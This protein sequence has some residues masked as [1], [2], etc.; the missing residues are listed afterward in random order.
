MEMVARISLALVV[1]VGSVGCAY[2]D[3]AK[4]PRLKSRQLAGVG[5]GGNVTFINAQPSAEDIE[6]GSAGLGRSLH[7]NL[8]QWTEAAI[9]TA[10]RAL[11]TPSVSA[12][13]RP[14]R[15]LALS[16]TRADLDT[17]VW[18]FQCKVFLDVRLD[19]NPA[20]EFEGERG[21]MSFLRVCDAAITEAV[22]NMLTD[23]AVRNYLGAATP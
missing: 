23:N 21:S 8:N 5:G 3:V 14:A 9:S 6:V 22:S 18:S 19:G 11:T 1:I 12:S 2:Q 4:P 16:I 17:G 7:A 20:L 10:Q 13:N 15:V